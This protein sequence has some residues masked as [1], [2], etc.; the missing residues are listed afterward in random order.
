MVRPR[1]VLLLITKFSMISHGVI[2][3]YCTFFMKYIWVEVHPN[4]FISNLYTITIHFFT[5]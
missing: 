4:I 1:P 3:P 2:L 5:R